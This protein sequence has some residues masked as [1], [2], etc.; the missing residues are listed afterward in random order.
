MYRKYVSMSHPYPY[1]VHVLLVFFI[2]PS[3]DECCD[4]LL[5]VLT[6]TDFWVATHGFQTVPVSR[7]AS[8]T[9]PRELSIR[10]HLSGA[11]LGSAHLFDSQLS[12]SWLW[13]IPLVR[14]AASLRQQRSSSTLPL[15][16]CRTYGADIQQFTIHRPWSVRIEAVF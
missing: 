9:D 1:I 14:P 6:P 8:R 4:S 16:V 12:Q 10:F 2:N 13:L 7:D 15:S 3:T 5:D 11:G